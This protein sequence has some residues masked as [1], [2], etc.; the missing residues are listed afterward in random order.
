VCSL[1]C[2]NFTIH[3][4]SC[5]DKLGAKGDSKNAPGSVNVKKPVFATMAV[6]EDVVLQRDLG[7]L[8]LLLKDSSKADE[9]R[10]WLI[11]QGCYDGM[12]RHTSAGQHVAP[13]IGHIDL[14]QT[15]STLFT[16]PLHILILVAQGTSLTQPKQARN[17]NMNTLISLNPS[18]G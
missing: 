5:E 16:W 3:E 1:Q 2:P 18:T 8:R 11:R 10:G 14:P 6:R 7:A 9:V 15:R 13:F 12:F 17:Q 4:Y